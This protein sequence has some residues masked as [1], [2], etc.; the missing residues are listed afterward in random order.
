[1]RLYPAL[2]LAA[3]FLALTGCATPGCAPTV[4]VR[5]LAF[6]DFHGH[7]ETPAWGFPVPDPAAPGPPALVRSG[8]AAHL[9]TALAEL[10]KGHADTVTVAAGDLVGASPLASALFFDEPTVAALGE[11]GLAYSAVGNHE[12]DRGRAELLR[13]AKGGCHPREGCFGD[14]PWPGARF[15][16]LAAN[17]IDTATGASFLPGHAVREIQGI[18][19]GFI[20]AVLRGTPG[21][22]LKSGIAGLSFLD[23]AD[24]IN[25]EVR[26]LQAR[27]VEAI[28]VLIHEG[29]Q[30]KGAFDDPQCP[31]FD[32]PIISIV[33]RLDPAV[34]VVVSGHTHQAYLC[35]VDGRLVTSAGA[36]GR[37]V[38]AIDL[39]LDRATRDVREA[40]AGN[41]I[42]ATG[43]YAAD[44]AMARFVAATVARAEVQSGRVVGT[45]AGEVSP[46]ADRAGESALGRLVADAQLAATREANGAVVAF[47]NP[48]GLRAPLTSRRADH[49][50]TRGDTYAVQPFGNNLVTLTLTGAQLL[51]ALE[52]QWPAEAGA[53]ARILAVSAGF[54]YAWEASRPP[55][56][57]IVPGSVSLDGRALDPLA[58]YRVTVNTY[59]AAGGDG[60]TVFTLGTQASGGPLDLDALEDWL[61]QGPPGAGLAARRIRRLD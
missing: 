28:V 22:V 48:G 30:A 45:L 46:L 17:V 39:T 6:N 7:L 60:F 35:R 47:T 4:A 56:G 14:A 58:R 29:G 38:T 54:S 37:V 32:G 55:G 12:F 24:A 59:L 36:Y 31:G 53:R 19:V 8:G 21:I 23:E 49:A 40:R 34:D 18:P 52:E 42:V 51:Q 50:L 57:R 41:F 16:W 13:L 11:M 26:L 33:R 9:A 2:G 15:T 3:A 44:P 10:R 5:L 25:A 61:R 27:G 1:M 43:T 20:G